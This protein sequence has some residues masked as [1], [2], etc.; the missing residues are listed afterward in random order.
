MKPKIKK[1]KGIYA[2][3]CDRVLGFSPE[4]AYNN[5]KKEKKLMED[6]FGVAKSSP[7]FSGIVSKLLG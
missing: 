2:W 5:W 6:I 7:S 1:V 3:E 4:G